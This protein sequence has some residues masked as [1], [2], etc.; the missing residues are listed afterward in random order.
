MELLCVVVYVKVKSGC[1]A[2]FLAATEA[3]ARASRQEPGCARFDA[4]QQLDDPASFVLL[5]EYRGEAGAAAHKATA[6]YAT[7][8]DTVQE[9]MAEPRRSVKYR[10]V[11]A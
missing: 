3:N 4:R 10:G 5:E 1:E 6:H 9:M 11:E 8:R 7:W 2:A